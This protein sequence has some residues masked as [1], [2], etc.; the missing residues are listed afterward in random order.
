MA[1]DALCVRG[2]LPRVRRVAFYGRGLGNGGTM[3]S[4]SDHG[5][6]SLNSSPA[7][8]ADQVDVLSYLP[9][10]LL[11][12]IVE[13]AHATLRGLDPSEL[14][15]AARP[16]LRFDRRGL[17]S[18]AAKRQIIAVLRREPALRTQVVAAVQARQDVTALCDAWP[19]DDH[20][21]MVNDAGARGDLPVLV[22]ALWASNAERADFGLGLCV[23]HYEARVDRDRE[24]DSSAALQRHIDELQQRLDRETARTALFEAKA[25]TATAKLRDERASRRQREQSTDAEVAAAQRLQ[26][27]AEAA[28]LAAQR[29][30]E[31]LRRTVA[32]E[33]EKVAV[34]ERVIA[35]L[36][37][38]IAALQRMIDAPAVTKTELDELRLEVGGFLGRI[39]DM[40][41]RVE[42]AAEVAARRPNEAKPGTSVGRSAPQSDDRAAPG[43]RSAAPTRRTRPTLAGGLVGDSVDGASAMLASSADLVLVVDGYN[44]SL[45]AWPEASLADQRE[46]LARALHQ[47]HLRYGCDIV[48][49]FDGDGTE[50]VKPLRRAGLCVVFSAADH[51]ADELVVETVASL[52]KRI[53]A[54]VASSDAWVREHAS[55]EGAVVIGAATVLAVSQRAGRR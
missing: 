38:E 20:V 24:H 8:S 16:L 6:E 2:V 31:T 4:V 47:I 32:R 22:A 10:P 46:R 51:E 45:R 39:T 33:Q 25:E 28:T 21:A 50:G 41:R 29:E 23:A 11:Q 18:S 12:T 36:R 54:L 34:N 35:Q 52:P 44:V 7:P 14:S 48:C 19:N 15:S 27:A 37:E 5:G 53:P 1:L 30:T 13:V 49:C 55:I 9:D 40:G 17:A 3:T 26:R 43:G 42:A